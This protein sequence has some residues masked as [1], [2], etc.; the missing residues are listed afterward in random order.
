MSNYTVICPDCKESR[1]VKRKPSKTKPAQKCRV[2][3]CKARP[4]KHGEYKTKLYMAWNNMKKRT[5]GSMNSVSRRY[6]I[7]GIK[8]C[9]E[10]SDDFIAFKDWS[11]ANGYIEDSDL[12]LDREN[13]SKDY[14]PDNC[15]WA[16]KLVQSQNTKLLS[17]MNTSGYRG[18]SK[19]YQKADNIV[20]WRARVKDMGK[21]V[22]LGVFEDINEA[23]KAYN[24]YVSEHFPEMPLNKI[25]EE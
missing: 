5:S 3:S 9:S 22:S 19:A 21:E 23:A 16:T 2:C 13:G 20:R 17:C 14:S 12:S 24:N 4:V 8:V 18:V 1:E 25:T 7:A 6:T 11:Y 15:R 10:W